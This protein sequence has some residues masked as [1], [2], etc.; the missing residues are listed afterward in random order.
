MARLYKEQP[1]TQAQLAEKLHI[2]NKTI[3]RWEMG[4]GY[5]D[6]TLLAPLAETL[7]T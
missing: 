5:P 1:L 2:S 7:G 3:S 6:V 4:E